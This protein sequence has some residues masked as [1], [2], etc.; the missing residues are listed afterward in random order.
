MAAPAAGKSQIID[1]SINAIRPSLEIL[2]DALSNNYEDEIYKER[3]AHATEIASLRFELLKLQDRLAETQRQLQGANERIE[4]LQ[5]DLHI[6]NQKNASL[7]EEMEATSRLVL[8]TLKDGDRYRKK[9]EHAKQKV[10]LLKEQ[11]KAATVMMKK[12]ASLLKE[13]T[14]HH[15]TT[16]VAASSGSVHRRTSTKRRASMHNRA[17]S[18]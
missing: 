2:V 7:S 13:D 15:D 9:F 16:S 6:A 18:Y 12:A 1:C 10:F 4:G 11:G 5:E 14:D 17:Y 3:Q 8:S